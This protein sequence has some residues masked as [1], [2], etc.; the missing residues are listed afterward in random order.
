MC[1]W[2][3]R[4]DFIARTSFDLQREIFHLIEDSLKLVCFHGIGIV[5]WPEF[6]RPFPLFF[7]WVDGN[8]AACIHFMCVTMRNWSNHG[9]SVYLYI[10]RI[11]GYIFN[12]PTQI[13]YWHFHLRVSTIYLDSVVCVYV[14]AV[15][16]LYL[17]QT[18]TL[19]DLFYSYLVSS[20][21]QLQ[22]L[23]IINEVLT[24]VN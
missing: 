16:P 8:A 1:A 14:C 24:R 19:F 13:K 10:F 12:Q 17:S 3:N 7:Y 5:Q 20:Q 4:S 11:C 22:L 18:R 6:K 21:R 23:P 2:G 15:D 9:K